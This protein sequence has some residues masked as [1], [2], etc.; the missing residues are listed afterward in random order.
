L[1]LQLQGVEGAEPPSSTAGPKARGATLRETEGF[2]YYMTAHA[3]GTYNPL[4]C[5]QIYNYRPH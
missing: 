5:Y 4:K 2:P 1:F 3:I